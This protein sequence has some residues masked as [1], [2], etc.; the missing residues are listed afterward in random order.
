MQGKRGRPSL[1]DEFERIAKLYFQTA[2]IMKV[3]ND[4]KGKAYAAWSV[5]ADEARAKEKEHAALLKALLEMNDR[6]N[7]KRAKEITKLP[8]N[9]IP[10]EQR[11]G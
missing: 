8:A 3:V 9:V 11:G 5:L 10:M 6:V 4:A 2:E 7:A 1:E